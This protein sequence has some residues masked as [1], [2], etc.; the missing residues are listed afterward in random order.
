VRDWS[1]ESAGTR[2][3]VP[4]EALKHVQGTQ[5]EVKAS[6]DSAVVREDSTLRNLEKVRGEVV[7]TVFQVALFFSI[8]VFFQVWNQI[9]CRSLT[10][11]TSG[12]SRLFS[13]GAF[14]TIAGITAIGQVLIVTIGGAVFKVEPLDGWTWLGVVAGTASVLVFAEA[15]RLV[16][17]LRQRPAPGG[18]R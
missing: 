6:K 18:P 17:R 1:F 4:V 7:F 11:D 12:F 5:Y 14:L 10:P 2:A 13:N 16:R 9:N 8:Y 15:A 3:A